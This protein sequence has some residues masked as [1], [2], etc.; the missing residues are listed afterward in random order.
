MGVHRGHWK[1][2]YSFWK[3]LG[4]GTGVGIEFVEA[5]F[6]KPLPSG[7]SQDITGQEGASCRAP[8][9]YSDVSDWSEEKD[10]ETGN[11]GDGE[12]DESDTWVESP[13]YVTTDT[14]GSGE[15]SDDN[16]I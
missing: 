13:Q 12:E 16:V 6:I 4:V 8:N 9:I 10:S 14:G 15:G 2:N 1:A 3:K 5:A 7:D 11:D